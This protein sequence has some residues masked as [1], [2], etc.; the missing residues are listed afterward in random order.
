MS[1]EGGMRLTMIRDNLNNLPEAQLPSGYSI[2]WFQP[3]MEKDWV[4]IQQKAET[5]FE[6]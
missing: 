1:N 4:R 2:Q 3:G 5:F 6:N